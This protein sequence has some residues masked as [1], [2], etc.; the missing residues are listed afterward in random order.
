MPDMVIIK[1]RANF[2]NQGLLHQS[3]TMNLISPHIITEDL[4][5]SWYYSSRGNGLKENPKTV[6]KWVIRK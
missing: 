3:R 2:T 6:L 1:L 5:K 4:G